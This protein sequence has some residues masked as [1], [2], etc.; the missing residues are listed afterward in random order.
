MTA[1]PAELALTKQWTI[2]VSG[3]R[4]LIDNVRTLE[5]DGAEV[6]FV[7]LHKK[8]KWLAVLLGIGPVCYCP[9]T[10]TR[11]IEALQAEMRKA[12]KRA[13]CDAEEEQ[14]EGATRPNAKASAVDLGLDAAEENS[15][16]YQG[17]RAKKRQR[18]IKKYTN[19]SPTVVLRMPATPGSSEI[20]PITVWW[21]AS[22]HSNTDPWMALNR[23]TLLWLRRFLTAELVEC[24]RF[25]ALPE[26]AA[27]AEN[28]EQGAPNWNP[29]TTSWQ[30]DYTDARGRQRQK[31]W[32]VPRAPAQTFQAR[33]ETD[34]VKAA[35][36]KR[37]HMA[38]KIANKASESN[39]DS[40]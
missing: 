12:L 13:A 17:G 26:E 38:P 22:A 14:Q 10:G 31:T 33:A 1:A 9:L 39:G 5:V 23:Q 40:N 6:D 25:Q 21:Q 35:Q 27:Y 18:A 19:N 2:A 16:D 37:Q 34:A 28:A 29:V 24:S 8:A 3:A 36:Y 32:F 30:I 11:C 20:V 4:M 7:K 15:L